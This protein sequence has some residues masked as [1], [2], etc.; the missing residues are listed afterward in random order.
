M[1]LSEAPG[2]FL[3]ILAARLLAA[4]RTLETFDLLETTLE[5]PGIGNGGPIRARC[6]R[7]DAQVYSDHWAAGRWNGLLVLHQHRDIP[8]AGRFRDGRREDVHAGGG[9]VPPFLQTQ[10]S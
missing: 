7:L 1:L 10:A 9:H 6:Q 5:R 8:V 4:H 2:R 3:A